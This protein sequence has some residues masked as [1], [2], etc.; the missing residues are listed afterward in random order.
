[1]GLGVLVQFWRS[2]DQLLAYAK[3]RDSLHYPA[4]SASTSASAPAGIS[5]FG[6]RRTSFGPAST[7]AST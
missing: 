6:T 7:S 3:S 1:V 5:E 2:L 4:W